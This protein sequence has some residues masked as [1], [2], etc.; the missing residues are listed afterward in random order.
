MMYIGRQP[1]CA[2][3]PYQDLT[4][5]SCF[6]FWFCGWG[7]IC[8]IGACIFNS[9]ASAAHRRGDYDE[10]RRQHANARRCLSISVFVGIAFWIMIFAVYF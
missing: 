2:P 3:E 8:S 1:I 4:L 9:N 7:W 5:F 6:A 10:Y